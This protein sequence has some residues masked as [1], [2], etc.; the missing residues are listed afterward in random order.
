MVT[1]QY[2]PW[3]EHERNKE[4]ERRRSNWRLSYDEKKV[5]HYWTPPYDGPDLVHVADKVGHAGVRFRWSRERLRPRRWNSRG[6]DDDLGI[7]FTAPLDK[8]LNVSAYKPGDFKQFYA[9]P[10]TRA[11]YL[12]WAPLLLAAEDWH[13]KKG[14]K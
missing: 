3:L 1:G 10:R 12:Q 14:A 8:V 4:Y 6:N 7:T 11:E 5:S 2:V 13:S 9:D